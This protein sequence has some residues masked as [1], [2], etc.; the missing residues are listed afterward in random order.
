[1]MRPVV[2]KAPIVRIVTEGEQATKETACTN[3]TSVVKGV[4]SPG[5]PTSVEER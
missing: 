5:C 4:L 2:M 3:Y 1:M